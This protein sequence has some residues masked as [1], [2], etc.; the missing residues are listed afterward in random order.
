M[1]QDVFVKPG[2]PERP[3][4]GEDTARRRSTGASYQGGNKASRQQH[5]DH[6]S[7]KAVAK[8]E[9]KKKEKANHRSKET[10]EKQMWVRDMSITG[11]EMPSKAINSV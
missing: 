4:S 1:M 2:S 5:H 3:D 11:S 7:P 8:K 6:T 9:K 10:K